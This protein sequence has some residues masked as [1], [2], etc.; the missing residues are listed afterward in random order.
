M[1][2][3]PLGCASHLL[4]PSLLVLCL[5]TSSRSL[6]HLSFIWFLSSLEVEGSSLC[7]IGK[8]GVLLCG[9]WL[10][11]FFRGVIIHYYHILVR[12]LIVFSVVPLLSASLS[13]SL[14]S[15]LYLPYS[16]L[17]AHEMLR[18]EV[19]MPCPRAASAAAALSLSLFSWFVS[20]S[21]VYPSPPPSKD[22]V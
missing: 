7:F 17:F 19:G 15:S 13:S 18:A 22:P 10:L 14:S 5:S 2:L 1:H 4:G 8:V 3:T 12:C 11:F 6:C 20:Y 9:C 16:S 21:F